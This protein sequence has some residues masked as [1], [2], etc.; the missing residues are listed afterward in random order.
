M[1]TQ[2]HVT[3]EALE[4]YS[5]GRL[6]E[7]KTSELEE[8]ILICEDCQHR[9]GE[10]DRYQQVMRTALAQKT[11]PGTAARGASPFLSWRWPSVA[12]LSAAAFAAVLLI[13]FMLRGPGEPQELQLIAQRGAESQAG[14]ARAGSPL[15]L[16]VDTTE[17]GALAA[18]R[19]EVVNSGGETMWNETVGAAGSLLIAPVNKSLAAG[20]YWVR[21]YRVDGGSAL[22]E[23]GLT[24]E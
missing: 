7:P 22:R 11:G 21:I 6:D 13:M 23:F 24:V 3:D 15:R 17:L 4:L 14:K 1:S 20:Q 5:L 16:R 19:V 9:L 8:H 10:E 2:T 18:Y 12:L